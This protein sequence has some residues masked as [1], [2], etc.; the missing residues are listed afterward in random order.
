MAI[1]PD[2]CQAATAL[3]RQ[4]DKPTGLSRHLEGWQLGL[5]SVGMAILAAALAIPRSVEPRDLPDPTYDPLLAADILRD[6]TERAQRVRQTPLPF[7]VRRVGEALRLLGAASSSL[8]DDP[9]GASG[10]LSRAVARA[11]DL[12]GKGPLLDLRAIQTELFLAALQRW[13]GGAPVDS[14]FRQLA[15]NFVEKAQ[16]SGWIRNDG[17]LAMTTLERVVFFRIRWSVLTG[18]RQEHP[19]RPSLTEWRIYYGFLLRHPEA[20]A[21]SEGRNRALRQLGYVTAL[22]KLDPEYPIDYARGIL[23]FQSGRYSESM[24]SFERHLRRHPEGRWTL[25]ARNFW[26]GAATLSPPTRE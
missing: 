3:K 25:R 6:Q 19:F 16:T 20:Q 4:G 7:A 24:D 11:L 18:L 22:S 23:L 14:E 13:E 15:G 12:H 1:G 9:V 26:L 2:H 10:E 8:D 17:R 21:R 5:V